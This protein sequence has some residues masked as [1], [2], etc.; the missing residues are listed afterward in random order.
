MSRCEQLATRLDRGIELVN[1][2]RPVWRD[3]RG[4]HVLGLADQAIDASARYL[5]AAEAF[6]LE[7]DMAEAALSQ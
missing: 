1:A 5:G 7:I 2:V 4:H 6:E 3:S